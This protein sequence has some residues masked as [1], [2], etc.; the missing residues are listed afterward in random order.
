MSERI[1]WRIRGGGVT[2]TERA[3][4]KTSLPAR[5]SALWSWPPSSPLLQLVAG[6]PSHLT[7]HRLCKMVLL[8][9][10]YVCSLRRYR[11]QLVLLICCGVGT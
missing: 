7:M 6:P 3:I 1:L 8:C 5:A 11:L 10:L 4:S 9:C 2:L